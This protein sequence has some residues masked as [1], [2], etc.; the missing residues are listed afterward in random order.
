V[1]DSP[2]I[3]ERAPQPARRKAPRDP[4]D[5]FVEERW[6]SARLFAERDFGPAIVDPCAGFGN[7][8]LSARAAGL[9]AYGCDLVKRARFV[10]GGR[11]FLAEDWRPPRGAPARFSIVCNPPFGGRKPTIRRFAEKA[12]LWARRVALLIPLRRWAPAGDWLAGLPLAEKLTLRDRTSLWPG[13]IYAEIVASGAE[14]KPGREEMCWLIFDR[15][16]RGP[17]TND[18]LRRQA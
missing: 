7:I 4:H 13:A 10:S 14:L 12:L 5:H 18:W 9:K 15:R 1:T 11:D 8:V 6:V 16:H 2:L 17:S 3:P